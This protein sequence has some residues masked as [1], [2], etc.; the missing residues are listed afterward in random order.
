MNKKLLG[1]IQSRNFKLIMF[2]LSS[3]FLL[4]TIFLA[5]RPEPFLKFGYLGVFVFNIFS[6]GLFLMPSLIGK[7]NLFMLSL[8]CAFG[9]SINESINWIMGTSSNIILKESS[10]EKKIETLV[11][12]YET[13]A[14]FFLALIPF[15][16]DVVGIIAGRLN[17]TYPRFITPIFFARVIR[18]LLFGLFIIYLKK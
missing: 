9:M 13:S 10:F 1:V 11:R 4:F 5:F 6:S 14:I 12:K 2:I 15:P 18:F 17:I 3:L 7:M 16:F 8:V